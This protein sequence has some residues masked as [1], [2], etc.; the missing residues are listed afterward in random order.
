MILKNY[1]VKCQYKKQKELD[2]LLTKNNYK[3]KTHIYNKLSEKPE[4]FPF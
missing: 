2:L 4:F 1:R 3:L